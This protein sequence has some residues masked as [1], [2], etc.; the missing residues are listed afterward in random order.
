LDSICVGCHIPFLGRFLWTA[1]DSFQWMD[2]ITSYLSRFTQIRDELGAVGDILDSSKLVRT[3]LNG[4]TKSWESFVHGI[5]AREHMPSWERLWD[6]F[7]Q[8][9]TKRGSGSTSQ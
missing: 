7:I 9:E 5:V 4:F 6:N 2:T 3:P 8:E 1:I